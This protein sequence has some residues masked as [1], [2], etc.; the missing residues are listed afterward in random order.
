MKISVE[1]KLADIG[2]S[3]NEIDK[4]L[5]E[6]FK[7]AVAWIASGAQTYWIRLAQERL[8]SR[9]ADYINGLRQAESFKAYVSGSSHVY[10]IQLVGRMPNNFEF[11]MGGFDMKTVRPGWLGGGKAK[12]SEDGSKYIHIPFRHSKTSTTNIPS[13]G[14]RTHTM[15]E[16]VKWAARRH[17]LNRMVRAGSRV[18]EGPVKRIP[19]SATVHPYLRGLTRIQKGQEETTASGLQRG[20]STLMT[21]RTMSEKSDPS[22]WI[23]PGITGANLLPLVEDWVDNELGKVIK[24]IMG[25]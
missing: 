16:H 11:G 19:T 12:T 1:A 14:G 21:F 13:S 3:L 8:G 2:V 4:E 5:Q 24:S 25:A 18:V 22:S 9:R 17:G 10:E 20:S 7:H 23:H 6:K 15:Q